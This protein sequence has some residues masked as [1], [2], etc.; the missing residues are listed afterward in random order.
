MTTNERVKHLD[1][2]A[3]EIR[4]ADEAGRDILDAGTQYIEGLEDFLGDDP[5]NFL[6]W[7][8]QNVRTA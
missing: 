7:F 5:E 2:L 3:E 6:Q 4:S 8:R 1:S